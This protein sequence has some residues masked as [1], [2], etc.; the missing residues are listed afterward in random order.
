MGPGIL[1]I[2]AAHAQKKGMTGGVATSPSRLTF[3]AWVNAKPR[4]HLAP[5]VVIISV[6]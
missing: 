1:Q 6:F 4:G 2:C 3:S 5:C